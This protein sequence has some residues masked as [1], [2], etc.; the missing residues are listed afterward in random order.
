VLAADVKMSAT[1]HKSILAYFEPL[2][3]ECLFLTD[4]AVRNP[5]MAAV[6]FG[7]QLEHY[8]LEAFGRTF[9]GVSVKKFSLEPKDVNQIVMTFSISFK[10]SSTEIASVA[11]YLQDTLPI[12]LQP[13]TGELDL[14]GNA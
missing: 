5:M 13:E 10:P 4:G 2:L 14:G 12:R 11:E 1:V 8:R 9:N 3:D 6:Q 7:H